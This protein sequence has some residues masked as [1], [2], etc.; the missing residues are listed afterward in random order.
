[1]FGDSDKRFDKHFAR[2]Q[3]T[4]LVSAIV[5]GITSL[6]VLVFVGWIVIK[7]LQYFGVI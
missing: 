7:L 1:M 2:T 5:G 6:A 4:I 3:K